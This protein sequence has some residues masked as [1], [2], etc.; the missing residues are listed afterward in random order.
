MLL[1]HAVTILCRQNNWAPS[2]HPV[3]FR[4]DKC[5]DLIIYLCSETRSTQRYSSETH[6]V[7]GIFTSIRFLPKT[8][9]SSTGHPS[10]RNLQVVATTHQSTEAEV[11]DKLLSLR[12]ANASVKHLSCRASLWFPKFWELL[13]WTV[14]KTK[15]KLGTKFSAFYF[16]RGWNEVFDTAHVIIGLWT[17]LDILSGTRKP[18]QKW[19]FCV[20]LSC[21]I[22][23]RKPKYWWPSW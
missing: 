11:E 1:L 8:I 12:L 20:T 14:G 19:A 4:F 10:L 5:G 2:W 6:A 23:V 18:T 7:V 17:C 16:L 21:F 9:L 3:K 13:Q 22:R 15:A